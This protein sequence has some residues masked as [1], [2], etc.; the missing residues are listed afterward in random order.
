MLQL[1]ASR[2]APSTRPRESWHRSSCKQRYRRLEE[3]IPSLCLTGESGGYAAKSSAGS[4]AS[5]SI[6][7]PL[8]SVA[9]APVP[10]E[11]QT[12]QDLT[13][14]SGA[15]TSHTPEILEHL[16]FLGLLWALFTPRKRLGRSKLLQGHQKILS[17]IS[18]ESRSCSRLFSLRPATNEGSHTSRHSCRCESSCKKTLRAEAL[19]RASAIISVP[20]THRRV[21]LHAS[22]C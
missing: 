2:I 15:N 10:S 21:V 19:V 13:R 12:A 6:L 17:H 16:V 4:K 14:N 1:S 11:T 7:L 5:H 8:G 18:C 3:S 22:A 9:R 20:A